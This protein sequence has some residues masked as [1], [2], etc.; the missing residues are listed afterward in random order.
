MAESREI[1]ESNS[2]VSNTIEPPSLALDLTQFRSGKWCAN[3]DLPDTSASH[4]DS[5]FSDEEEEEE[6]I[7][8][9]FNEDNSELDT[10]VNTKKDKNREGPRYRF[11]ETRSALDKAR[12]NFK[13]GFGRKMQEY[14]TRTHDEVFI[15]FHYHQSE[16]AP[17]QSNSNKKQV[18]KQ[19]QKIKKIATDLDLF[20]LY[21]T[22]NN[23]ASQ[24]RQISHPSQLARPSSSSNPTSTS[25]AIAPPAPIGSP[26]A[27]RKRCSDAHGPP[28]EAR[29]HEC[30]VVL[31]K[32]PKC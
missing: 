10:E 31:A 2:N 9:I 4:S 17:I 5:L 7:W 29:C 21:N 16:P 13:L 11:A 18:K 26:S 12:Y 30:K 14:K 28:T 23:V 24:S 15:A 27:K 3:A 20:R 6:E 25:T 32:M 19:K 1:S 8:K 22:G